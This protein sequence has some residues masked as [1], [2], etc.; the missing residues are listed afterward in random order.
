MAVTVY[1]N[2][3]HATLNLEFNGK[4]KEVRL[5]EIF[6]A[7]GTKVFQGDGLQTTIDISNNPEG[8]HFVVVHLATRVITKKF[9][10]LK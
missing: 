9:L 6:N 3:A 1:P 8:L 10:L 7:T 4:N 2:P 5:I